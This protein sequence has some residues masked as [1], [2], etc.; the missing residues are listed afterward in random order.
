MANRDNRPS[1][2]EAAQPAASQLSDVEIAEQLAAEKRTAAATSAPATQ[3]AV[4]SAQ[5]PAHT[6]RVRFMPK[7]T[8][9]QKTDSGTTVATASLLGC[10]GALPITIHGLALSLRDRDR[11]IAVYMPGPMYQRSIGPAQIALATPIVV[12][13]KPVTHADDPAGTRAMTLLE[14]SIRDAWATA[15]ASGQPFGRDWPLAL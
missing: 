4:E 5:P 2:A 6:M 13:G 11:T 3:P 15:N 8:D 7:P 10:F 9:K 1:V 12:N 14:Q